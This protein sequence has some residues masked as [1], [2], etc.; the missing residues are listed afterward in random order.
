[1]CIGYMY[2]LKCKMDD[3][4]FEFVLLLIISILCNPCIC[5]LHFA[6]SLYIRLFKEPDSTMDIRS[7]TM[8]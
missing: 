2:L 8:L 6:H 1:M 7:K 5:L 3:G 4:E